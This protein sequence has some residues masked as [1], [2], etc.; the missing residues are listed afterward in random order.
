[1]GKNDEEIVHL[2]LTHMSMMHYRKDE[3]KAR[4]YTWQDETSRCVF[5]QSC[6]DVYLHPKTGISWRNPNS[7]DYKISVYFTLT[8][9]NLNS[10]KDHNSQKHTL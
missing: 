10:R 6:R 9:R 8:N 1:M 4:K 3:I 2:H 5:A 7:W